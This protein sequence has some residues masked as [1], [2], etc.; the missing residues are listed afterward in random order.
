MAEEKEIKIS[1]LN[2]L[3][4][5]LSSQQED[6][7]FPLAGQEYRNNIIRMLEHTKKEIEESDAF[8]KE[9]GRT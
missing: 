3:I 7:F 6:T 4:R 2:D 1:L 9:G 8:N 5:R